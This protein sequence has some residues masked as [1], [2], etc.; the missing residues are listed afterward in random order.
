MAVPIM[1]GSRS[2]MDVDDGV[3]GY[4]SDIPEKIRKAGRESI[5]KYVFSRVGS[6]VKAEADAADHEAVTARFISLL[7]KL[8]DH[9]AAAGAGISVALAQLAELLQTEMT[10]DNLKRLQHLHA[11]TSKDKIVEAAFSS[12]RFGQGVMVKVAEFLASGKKHEA[13]H[14]TPL[15]QVLI[16]ESFE[17]RV[18]K[19]KPCHQL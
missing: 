3:V 14:I 17:R 7:R 11:A 1:L 6:T 15:D 9:P 8:V 16:R 12:T 18:I 2:G 10:L 13:R 5:L 4:I 19:I